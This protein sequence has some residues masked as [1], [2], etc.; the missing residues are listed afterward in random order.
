MNTVLNNTGFSIVFDP[1]DVENETEALIK[2]LSTCDLSCEAFLLKM[3]LGS[4]EFLLI[5]TS[6]L[7][8]AQHGMIYDDR[9]TEAI[10]ITI[11]CQNSY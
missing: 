6:T 2:A 11:V 9:A 1:D 4:D 8:E 3:L 5:D 10:I 7:K